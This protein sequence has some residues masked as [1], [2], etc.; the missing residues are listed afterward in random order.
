[1]KHQKWIKNY[2]RNFEKLA[3]EV[4]DLRYDS[5]EEF[6]LLLSKKIGKDSVAD[7]RRG[8]KR[9]SKCLEECSKNLDSASKQIKESWRISRPFMDEEG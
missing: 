5:L 2:E 9:L 7:E 1:M 3:E 6:L 4:G 8:R